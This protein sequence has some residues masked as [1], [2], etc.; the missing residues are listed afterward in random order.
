MEKLEPEVVLPQVPDI[1]L[2]TKFANTVQNT[3]DKE[4]L[5][6]A[7]AGLHVEMDPRKSDS[8]WGVECSVRRRSP[9]RQ[10][11]ASTQRQLLKPREWSRLK[12]SLTSRASQS[13]STKKPS[14]Q[15]TPTFVSL[16]LLCSLGG[17]RWWAMKYGRA[18]VQ[19]GA[20]VAGN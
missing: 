3:C 16:Q 14:K 5:A 18:Q 15:F 19:G 11:S 10:W 20:E 13:L 8:S 17:A 4:R 2:P 1:F 9:Y 12:R 6:V 7:G